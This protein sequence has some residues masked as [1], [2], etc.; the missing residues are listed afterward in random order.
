MQNPIITAELTGPVATKA[1]GP[2]MPGTVAEIAADAYGRR[3]PS[4]SYGRQSAYQEGGRAHDGGG[5]RVARFGA[6]GD[7]G[8]TARRRHESR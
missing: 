1:D 6:A 3:P 5:H 7:R 8:I 2:L 4:P